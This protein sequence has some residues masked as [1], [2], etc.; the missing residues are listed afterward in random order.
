MFRL[1][2]FSQLITSIYLFIVRT[3]SIHCA[4]VIDTTHAGASVA[5][6]P[7]DVFPSDVGRGAPPKEFPSGGSNVRRMQSAVAP[8]LFPSNQE[9]V[10]QV[11]GAPI[12]GTRLV[13]LPPCHA[14]DSGCLFPTVAGKLP[15]MRPSEA[16]LVVILVN[17]RVSCGSML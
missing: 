5:E 7:P 11:N 15:I 10:L 2:Q 8:R 4:P 1:S 16:E 3:D 17:L 14:T 12:T 6:L 13:T 9:G